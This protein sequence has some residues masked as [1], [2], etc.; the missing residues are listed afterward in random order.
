MF[1]SKHSGNNFH[2][3]I[4]R[5]HTHAH[6]WP[7]LRTHIKNSAHMQEKIIYSCEQTCFCLPH[8]CSLNSYI[9]LKSLSLGS[10][11]CKSSVLNA[12]SLSA[13]PECWFLPG[14]NQTLRYSGRSVCANGG[15][16]SIFFSSHTTF[17]YGHY[18]MQSQ[19]FF[20]SWWFMLGHSLDR[21]MFRTWT[22]LFI[23]PVY[24]FLLCKSIIIVNII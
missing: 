11:N 23:K 22:N 5:L 1:K 15:Q 7:A 20:A 12:I 18:W 16:N 10:F 8:P 2:L 4:N 13:D 3:T 24:P 9:E 17:I 14:A 19:L 21:F 6:R